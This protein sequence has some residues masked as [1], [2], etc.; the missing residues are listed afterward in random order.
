M[1]ELNEQLVETPD[2]TAHIT[3]FRLYDLSWLCKNIKSEPDL[4]DIGYLWVDVISVDQQ[5]KEGKKETILKMNQIYQYATYILAVPD[6]HKGYLKKNVVNKEILNLVYYE[7]NETIYEEIFNNKNSSTDDSIN[8]DTKSSIQQQQYTN[9]N[10]DHYSFIQKLTNDWSNRAWVIREYQ[11]AKEKYMKHGTPLKYMF[12][13]L[14]D[15]NAI[16]QPFFSYHFNDNVDGDKNNDTLTLTDVVD[17]KTFHQFV[18][19]KFMQRPHLEMILSSNVARNEDRFNAILPSWNEY[20]H[21]IK[22]ITEWNITD[23]TS[24]KAKLLYTCS[25][26]GGILPS[27]ASQYNMDRLTIIEKY[28]YDNVA[29]KEF[30]NDLLRSILI[31]SNK[32]KV[33]RIQ[34]F[35]NEYKGN[36]KVIWAENL[37]SIQ[38]EQQKCCISVKPNSY[39]ITNNRF[40][41]SI[42]YISKISLDDG[43]E[44]QKVF[45]SFF[46]FAIHDHVD[47]PL[48]Y[49]HGSNICLAGNMHKNKW[50]LTDGY[51]N[52]FMSEQFCSDC[53][54][55]FN[56]Y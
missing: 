31:Y 56:I 51:S 36:S 42:K 15:Y 37:A 30:E 10:S 21:L 54:Y 24:D 6:L 16:G 28:D 43:D 20:K 39:F 13:I 23:M 26:V 18:K 53:N 49:F 33:A 41:I 44:I 1:G 11:I 47:D 29:Y 3:S 40:F 50:V 25:G 22:N 7:Y 35:I 34:Q 55:T 12:M 9:S 45:I 32:K 2:Y 17:Y 8:N 46:I 14:W 19:S 27:F 4:C 5:N 38:F 48:I 52:N